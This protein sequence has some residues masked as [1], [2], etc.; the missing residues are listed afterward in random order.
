[1]SAQITGGAAPIYPSIVLGFESER[2][3]GSLV[4]Q[5][6]G[7]SNPDVTLR[8]AQLRSGTLKLTFLSDSSEEDS[9]TSE[10][11]LSQGTVFTLLETDR[12]SVGMQ[13]V[14]SGKIRRALD[15]ETRDDWTVEVDYTEVA[16]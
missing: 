3:G 12:S 6:L 13:F 11:T 15:A 1:M 4:H 5:I 9:R 2:D 7:N 16:S 14:V 8:P 10:L